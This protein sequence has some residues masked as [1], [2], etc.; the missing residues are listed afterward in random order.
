MATMLYKFK[1]KATGD[2]IMLGPQGDQLLQLLG[3][4]PATQGIF[5][6]EA[7]PQAWAQLEQA[8][9][10]EESA[11]R[12]AKQQ[13]PTETNA[14]AEPEEAAAALVSLRRRVWP[15]IEMLKRAHAEGQAVV[16][17]V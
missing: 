5:E 11:R 6:P 17:G 4:S 10:D 9:Q 12:D 7:M 3:R 13:H 1:S 15:F 2:L 16:W 8:V 14:D